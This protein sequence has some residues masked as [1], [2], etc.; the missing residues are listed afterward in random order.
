MP[1]FDARRRELRDSLTNAQQDP[2]L[3]G[4][5]AMRLASVLEEYLTA[6]DAVFTMIQ[7]F[8][9]DD[10]LDPMASDYASKFRDMTRAATDKLDN[11]LDGL[12]NPSD[13]AVR[14][15]EQVS[16]A[17]FVFWGHIGGLKLAEAR[18]R[19][20]MDVQIVRDLTSVMDKKWQSLG[21][22]DLK[23]EDAEQRAAQDI[24]DL[25]ERSLAEAMPYWVQAGTG[26]VAVREAYKSFFASITDHAKELLVGAGVP[27]NVVEGLL[28]L[29]SWANN[30]A[31]ITELA[32]K[33]GMPVQEI[34]DW[35]NRIRSMNLGGLIQYRVGTALDSKTKMVLGY[36]GDLCKGLTPIIEGAYESRMAAFK[37]QLDNEGVVIV[38]FGNIRDQVDRFLKA[39]NLETMRSVHSAVIASMD[40][41]DSSL[42]TDGMKRD[43]A[44]VRRTL[45][46]K[47][48]TRRATA[49]KVFDDFYRANDGRFLGGLNSETETA[50]LETNKWIVTTDGIIRVGMDVK[51]REW[52]QGVTVL[53]AGP[54]EAFDQ[55]E[56]AFLGLPLDVRDPFKKG[57]N[58]IVQKHLVE[59]NGE[60]DK[61]IAVLDKCEIMV[62]AKKVSNDMDRARLAQAL[63]QT[64]R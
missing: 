28:T 53:N 34:F 37:A 21:E 18:D 55:V 35:I 63:R 61:T 26:A 5:E 45:K 20:V 50:L 41:I 64:I 11:M 44:D 4:S 40:G 36:L 54:K 38:S 43:W 32:L 22:E 2:D 30:V 13:A 19:M 25:L 17:E 49:E 29:A 59:I 15:A 52:R 60:V 12:T 24:K 1:S 10:D 31:D 39:C 42:A 57:L 47:F 16:F 9:A 51:L 58:E 8:I 3:I 6:R 46:D 48:D 14:W 33:L 62:N 56:N 7:T 27:R 23:V